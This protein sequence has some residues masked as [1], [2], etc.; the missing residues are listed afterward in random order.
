MGLRCLQESQTLCSLHPHLKQSSLIEVPQDSLCLSIPC[1]ETLANEALVV[2]SHH[3]TVVTIAFS[4]W[5]PL[6][7][8]LMV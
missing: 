2:P 4:Q 7:I 5:R 8:S 3:S 6:F 1:K